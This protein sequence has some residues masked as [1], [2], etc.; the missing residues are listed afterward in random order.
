MPTPLEQL[1]SR[2][3]ENM[4]TLGYSRED[5]SDLFDY[6]NRWCISN[7]NMNLSPDE[8]FELFMQSYGVS[9]YNE[10]GIVPEDDD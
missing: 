8:F 4:E 3:F 9:L 5:D 1:R 10:H 7:Q 6:A 2:L